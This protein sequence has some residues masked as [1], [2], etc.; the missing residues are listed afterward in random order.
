MKNTNEVNGVM[1][2]FTENHRV[3]GYL[4]KDHMLTLDRNDAQI[5]GTVNLA[6]NAVATFAA[7][8]GVEQLADLGKVQLI[9][10]RM[11]EEVI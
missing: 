1:V 5:Y 10:Y 3:A 11:I 6:V 7:T 2:K 8:Q 9:R 4:R